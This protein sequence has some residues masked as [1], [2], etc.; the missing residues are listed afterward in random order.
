MATC[1][2]LD[3]GQAWLNVPGLVHCRPVCLYT[4]LVVNKQVTVELDMLKGSLM[5]HQVC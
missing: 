3:P 2:A 5:Q 4:A 1:P